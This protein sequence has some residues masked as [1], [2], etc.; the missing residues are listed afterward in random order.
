MTTRSLSMRGRLIAVVLACLLVAACGDDDD[1]SVDAATSTTAIENGSEPTDASEDSAD[2]A[3]TSGVSDDGTEDVNEAEDCG[4]FEC[5]ESC[6][7]NA[8]DYPDQCADWTAS[9][10]APVYDP[11]WFDDGLFGA[12]GVSGE[13]VY[14]AIS[15]CADFFAGAGENRYELVDG[16]TNNTLFLTVLWDTESDVADFEFSLSAGGPTEF[17]A[18]GPYSPSTLDGDRQ[19]VAGDLDSGEEFQLL[20]PQ[21][22][23]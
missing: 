14:G 20:V 6:E 15:G 10:R 23:C 21:E 11:V 19:V 4:D 7:A 9:G 16:D 18:E 3:A 2:D 13:F 5:G 1:A 8:Q 12:Y 22:S 17:S